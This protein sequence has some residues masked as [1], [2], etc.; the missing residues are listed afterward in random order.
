MSHAFVQEGD[1]QSLS[2]ISPTLPAL[3]NFLT[4]ENNG[5]RVYEKK[6]KQLGNKYVHEMSNGLSYTKDENGRWSV[7]EL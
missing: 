4:R 6:L 3:I 7:I 2:D 1:D 5:V